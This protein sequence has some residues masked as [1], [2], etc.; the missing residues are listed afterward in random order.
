MSNLFK[1]SFLL[2]IFFGVNKLVALFRQVIIGRQFGFSPQIDAFNVSNNLPDLLFSLFAGGA[3]ALA[4]IPVFAEYISEYGP[5]QS[6]KLFSKVANILFILTLI[7]SAILAVFAEPLVKWQYGIAPGF[8]PSQQALVVN[9]MRIN[10]LATLVFSLS[11][12]TMSS[13]QAHKHFLLPAIAPILYNL[14][15]I[16]GALVLAPTGGIHFLNFTLPT[17]GFGIYGLAYGVVLG[18]ILHLAVQVPGLFKFKFKYDL[19]LGL[20]DAGVQKVIRL[21]GPRILTVMLI[22]VTF[23]FRD[24]IASRLATGSVTALTYGYFVLQV[25]E[26]LIG[27]A[28]ATALLPTLSDLVTQKRKEEFANVINKSIRIIIVLTLI[29][30]VLLSLSIEQLTRVVFNFDYNHNV[31]LAWTTRAFMVGLLGQCL[32][33]V[34]TRA[35]YAKQDAKTPLYATFVRTVLFIAAGIMSYKI[36][37][38]VS[39]A[40][41][42][43]LT[44]SLEVVILFFL[45]SR[46]VPK[47]LYMPDTIIRTVLGCLASS[48]VFLGISYFLPL[49]LILRVIIGLTLSSLVYLV[50]IK[51][52]LRMLVKL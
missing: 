51:K 4:F 1:A 15:Q 37:G 26:T 40:L 33:E 32:L 39:L 12:L 18:A 2:T 5:V 3:L 45:L 11:G 23:V 44:I 21:M 48:L 19:S 20:R 38:A 25:P 17:F 49:A 35:Y 14:G 47:L 9:L 42:D 8:S 31:L 41:A 50:F 52:E 10:L 36:F 6:W 27:T 30:T 46:N 22:Q 34:A 16:F 29:I 43:S 7:M 13:L 28:I 24:N